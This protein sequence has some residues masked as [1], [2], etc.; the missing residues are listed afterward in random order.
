LFGTARPDYL[1]EDG[2]D[3]RSIAIALRRAMLA[4]GTESYQPLPDSMI[5]ERARS[6]H[7]RRV[8]GGVEITGPT[9]EGTLDGDPLNGEH[10]A[11]IASTNTGNAPFAVTVA[12]S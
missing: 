7:Y 1:P 6:P 11:V 12:A 9:P 2:G 5:G 8:A 3:P 4:I 10:L